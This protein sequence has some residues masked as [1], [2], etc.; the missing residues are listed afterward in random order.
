[1]ERVPQ[2]FELVGG[3]HVPSWARGG[4]LPDRGGRRPRSGRARISHCRRGPLGWSAVLAGGLLALAAGCIGTRPFTVLEGSKENPPVHQVAATWQPNV[5]YTPDP[6]HGGTPIPGLAG[7]LYLFGPEFGHPMISEGSVVVDLYDDTP[8]ASGGKAKML[9]KWHLDKDTLKR[10]VRKDMIGEGY[11]IFLPWGTYR[12]EITQVHLMVSYTPTK[13]NPLY[14]P[15][16]PLNLTSNLPAPQVVSRTV[17]SPSVPTPAG[18]AGPG[19]APPVN[20]APGTVQGL[21]ASPAPGTAPLAQN[22]APPPHPFY[23]PRWSGQGMAAG[24]PPAP[25]SAPQVQ[26]PVAGPTVQPVSWPAP[27]A[28]AQPPGPLPQPQGPIPGVN[29]QQATWPVPNPVPGPQMPNQV[30]PTTSG[31]PVWP[32][33]AANLQSP[34]APPAMNAQPPVWPAVV[35]AGAPMVGPQPQYPATGMGAGQPNWPPTGVGA[36]PQNLVPVSGPQATCPAPAMVSQANCPAAGCN[37]QVPILA[38]GMNGTPMNW[39]R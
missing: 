33:Q 23:T 29:V 17:A 1:M 14:A 35:G 18:P 3:S 25:P 34:G 27:A 15:S 9:E 39:P 5:I 38:P 2:E 16:G 11:T 37:P 12:P 21:P 6:A 26:T 22:S 7:R 19:Q 30:A 13:G 4:A 32:P 36:Q 24:V 28:A 8:V 10:L 20:P 31:P